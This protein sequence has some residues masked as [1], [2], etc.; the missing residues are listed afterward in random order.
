TPLVNRA[1]HGTNLWPLL[2]IVFLPFTTLFYVF[3]YLPGIGLT[4]WGWV[5]VGLGLLLDISAYTG[6]GYS[7]R[8]RLPGY[9]RV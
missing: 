2:G 3:A 6:S 9:T 5:W 4:G 1:F 7:N 8:N